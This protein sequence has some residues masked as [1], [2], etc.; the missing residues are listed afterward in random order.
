MRKLSVSVL[1]LTLVAMLALP[2]GLV[3]ADDHTPKSSSIVDIAMADGRFNTLVA[4]VTEAG[5]A[6]TL[7]DDG[8]FTVFA[9][10]DEAFASA[11]ALMGVSAEDFLADKE[12]LTKIL[13]YH[14]VPGKIMAADVMGLESATTLAGF[15]LSFNTEMGV[16]INDASNVVIADI[17]A[18]N[19]VIHVI[20]NVLFPPNHLAGILVDSGIFNTLLAA[21]DETGLTAT[22]A[23]D[24]PFTIFAP[25]DE[26][27]AASLDALGLTVDDLLAD[28]AALT[29]I[30]LYHVVPGEVTAADVAGLRSVKTLNGASISIEVI[31][32]QVVLNGGQA[33]VSNPDLIGSNGVIHMISGVLLPA[34]G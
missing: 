30:L 9:P 4:A 15:D 21:L 5:L 7:A 26:A 29:D 27:F 14:V 2:V 31:D 22:L 33:T 25:T 23:E 3:R 6:D 20:D 1:L 8:P 24:G 19:G 10:T 28:P 12:A 11:L 16:R 17:E 18:G 34:E 13:L 32:G